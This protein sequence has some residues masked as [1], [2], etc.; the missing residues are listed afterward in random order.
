MKLTFFPYC[1]LLAHRAQKTGGARA[2]TTL[3]LWWKRK[4]IKK[5][6]IPCFLFS[7]W[8]GGPSNGESNH[9]FFFLGFSWNLVRD[10]CRANLNSKLQLL[11]E[12][13]RRMQSEVQPKNGKPPNE[14]SKISIKEVDHRSCHH[15]PS[16]AKP[17]QKLSDSRNLKKKNFSGFSPLILTIERP[18]QIY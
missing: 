17:S 6:L 2:T 18:L 10:P 16:L 15:P 12:K 4:A 11:L 7:C 3:L 9:W 5:K 13:P 1:F 8:A 14:K